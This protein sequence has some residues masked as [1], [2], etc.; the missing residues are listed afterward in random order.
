MFI[1]K[2]YCD[3][4]SIILIHNA[5]TKALHGQTNDDYSLV[6]VHDFVR[7]R[8]M[9]LQNLTSYPHFFTSLCL[10]DVLFLY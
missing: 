8:F 4:N 3:S 6:D 5:A 7:E 2:M 10:T 1:A 9:T